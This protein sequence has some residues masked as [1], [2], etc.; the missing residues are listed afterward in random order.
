MS[1]TVEVTRTESPVKAH[2]FFNGDAGKFGVLES[3]VSDNIVDVHYPFHFVVLDADA[4][5]VGGKVGMEKNDPKFKSNIAHPKYG[6]ELRVWLENDESNILAIGKWS[7]IKNKPALSKAK[8][9]ALIYVLADFGNGKKIACLHLHGRAYSAWLQFIQTEK[10]NPCGPHAFV[11]KGTSEM[12]GEIGRASLVPVFEITKVSADT[13]NLADEADSELQVWLKSQFPESEF[14]A[15]GAN[16]SNGSIEPQPRE[17]VRGNAYEVAAPAE[18][19]ALAAP[20]P[21]ED[22]DLPF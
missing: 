8:F 6:T 20:L 5:R 12:R 19:P 7:Q 11:V 10:I 18:N 13:L 2:V 4:Y 16:R 14:A 1:R 21:G 17:T 9:T 22:D 3:D 15:A